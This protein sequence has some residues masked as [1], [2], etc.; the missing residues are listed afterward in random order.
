[1]ADRKP[2]TEEA[3]IAAV[4]PFDPAVKRLPNHR[5]FLAVY[6]ATYSV[7][8]VE[9]EVAFAVDVVRVTR[10]WATVRVIRSSASPHPPINEHRTVS[11]RKLRAPTSGELFWWAWPNRDSYDYDGK[12]ANALKEAGTDGR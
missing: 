11:P 1:M 5:G 10:S 6:D 3:A 12:L 9:R 8:K 2:L 4:A 7:N